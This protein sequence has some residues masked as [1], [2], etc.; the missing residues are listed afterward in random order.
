MTQSIIV[1]CLI[2]GRL[3]RSHLAMSKPSWLIRPIVA[4]VFAAVGLAACGGTPE[5]TDIAMN[6]SI[7]STSG[8]T[9]PRIVGELSVQ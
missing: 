8:L 1:C 7:G 5:A 3:I 9:A 6:G 2:Y 4:A